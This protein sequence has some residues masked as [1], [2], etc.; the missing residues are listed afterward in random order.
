MDQWL[1]PAQS[2]PGDMKTVVSVSKLIL[3]HQCQVKILYEISIL[4]YESYMIKANGY[5]LLDKM[6]YSFVNTLGIF[7]GEIGYFVAYHGLIL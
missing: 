2:F 6:M 3:W 5:I 1:A 4:L 7:V